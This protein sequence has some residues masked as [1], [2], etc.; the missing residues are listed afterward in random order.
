MGDLIVLPESDTLKAEIDYL[1]GELSTLL[2]QRDELVFVV[3][4]NIE[5]EYMLKIGGLEHRAYRAQCTYLRLKRKLALIQAKLNRQEAIDLQEIDALLDEEF[6]EYQARLDEQ[7]EKMNSALARSKLEH[8]SEEE[9]K[10]LK[11]LYRLI[12]KALHPDLNPNLTDAQVELFYRAV[13]AYEDGNL[14]ELRIIAEMIDGNLSSDLS[15]LSAAALMQQRDRL[16]ELLETVRREMETIKATFPYTEKDLLKDEKAVEARKAELRELIE[17][18]EA[19]IRMYRER[20][21]EGTRWKN[22]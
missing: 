14:P 20:I 10:E 12:V 7:I 3:C 17:E 4:K 5:M 16:K 18:Y 13:E 9:S 22:G 1:R 2:A 6:A 19:A 11:K 15:E 8:L 21:D